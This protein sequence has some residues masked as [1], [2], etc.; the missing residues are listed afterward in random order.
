MKAAVVDVQ[1]QI[2]Q[3]LSQKEAEQL[4]VLLAKLVA[5]HD[6]LKNGVVS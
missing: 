4:T 1:G 3:P 2:L 5:G 6:I